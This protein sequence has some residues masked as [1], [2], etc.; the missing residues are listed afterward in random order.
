MFLRLVIILSMILNPLVAFA[1]RNEDRA[2]SLIQ[3]AMKLESQASNQDPQMAY[4]LLKRAEV[5]VEAELQYNEDVL[6]QLNQ[7]CGADVTSPSPVT[8]ANPVNPAL[9]N[10]D[11]RERVAS[12]NETIRK[13][14]PLFPA[15]LAASV[16]GE[17]RQAR[18]RIE[19]NYPDLIDDEFKQALALEFPPAGQTEN[20]TAPEFTP[21]THAAISRAEEVTQNWALITD[22][23]I[24]TDPE[25]GLNLIQL[26]D[27][28]PNYTE[29]LAQ[30]ATNISYRDISR[31]GLQRQRNLDPSVF[32]SGNRFGSVGRFGSGFGNQFMF[33][34]GGLEMFIMQ[35]NILSKDYE[36]EQ[37]ML[38]RRMG[39]HNIDRF[40]D[41]IITR[42]MGHHVAIGLL[43]DLGLG[44]WLPSFL[45]RRTL[46]GGSTFPQAT[47]SGFSNNTLFANNNLNPNGDPAFKAEI[48]TPLIA[49][50]DVFLRLAAIY[51][52]PVQS[53]SDFIM[54]IG[55]GLVASNITQILVSTLPTNSPETRVTIANNINK[56]IFG[57]RDNFLSRRRVKSRLAELQREEALLEERRQRILAEQ[58]AR[59]A[60]LVA[61]NEGMLREIEKRRGQLEAARAGLNTQL[62]GLEADLPA[63]ERAFARAARPLITNLADA[64]RAS[65]QS[66]LTDDDARI[67]AFTG[68]LDDETA[69]RPVVFG[70]DDPST[71]PGQRQGGPGA[72]Q[73]NPDGTFGDNP[74]FPRQQ[75]PVSPLPG[76][77]NGTGLP[78]GDNRFPPGGPDPGPNN[79]NPPGQDPDGQTGKRAKYT[80]GG[81]AALGLALAANSL[82]RL[83]SAWGFG[84]FM[85][86]RM[87]SKYKARHEAMGQNFQRL[88]MSNEAGKSVFKLMAMTIANSQGGVP[89]PLDLLNT[90]IVD[91]DSRRERNLK[92]Q[93]KFVTNIARS[94]Q[95]CEMSPEEARELRPTIMNL[96]EEIE[97]ER[98][99][100]REEMGCTHES[101]IPAEEVAGEDQAEETENYY[102]NY[103]CSADEYTDPERAQAVRDKYEHMIDLSYS[104]QFC[105]NAPSNL[106]WKDIV[107]EFQNFNTIG[108]DIG[109]ITLLQDAHNFD[110]LIR[111]GEIILQ[112]QYLDGNRDPNEIQ[113]FRNVILPVLG[114][115]N[116]V[117]MKYFYEYM[118]FMSRYG[119]LKESITSP[120]GFQIFVDDE[121]HFI[122][123]DWGAGYSEWQKPSLKATQWVLEPPQPLQIPNQFGSPFGSTFSG[124]Q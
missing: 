60:R 36:A 68:A 19:R 13:A 79:P 101:E 72:F 38:Y 18:A 71:F 31:T 9:L 66:P 116:S 91:T 115:L 103:N 124:F 34:P 15:D 80:L 43:L 35:T 4:V 28:L 14:C 22:A 114:L 109:D 78:T 26:A 96:Q 102:V 87:R 84:Q 89:R 67:R 42:G 105:G 88:L 106:A 7:S 47:G 17:L 33:Q 69:N 10:P 95:Y 117:A 32:S 39:S 41:E 110:D 63:K 45:Q 119:G 98:R 6:G 44:T 97:D 100:M 21:L 37:A 25:Q 86:S 58:D 118:A 107:L 40:A 24:A 23:E 12:L 29:A 49:H 3:A 50:T 65:G 76:N 94:A 8:T 61:R 74:N 93:L 52:Y 1:D 48:V 30:L 111:I 112:L 46:P 5:I 121:E 53:R 62:A 56:A 73:V 2:A 81:V 59:E 20:W 120:R 90:E 108:F 77:G 82:P 92:R 16:I 27:E 70:A 54:E 64:A 122:D 51:D 99:S 104:Y 57:P 11:Q 55:L 123:Y 85:K 83:A 75:G 113:F